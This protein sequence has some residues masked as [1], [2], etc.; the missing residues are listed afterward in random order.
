MAVN[1]MLAGTSL[2]P[3]LPHTA[4]TVVYIFKQ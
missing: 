4:A 3:P 2:L 1:H